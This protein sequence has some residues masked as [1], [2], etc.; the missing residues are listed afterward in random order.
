MAGFRLSLKGAVTATDGA[1]QIEWVRQWWDLG[2]LVWLVATASVALWL[3]VV[4][5]VALWVRPRRVR[6]GPDE[7]DLPGDEPP[8][9]ASLIT[10]SWS[11]DRDAGPATLLDLVARGHLSLRQAGVDPGAMTPD[12]A[13]GA[14]HVP[15]EVPPAGPGERLER[16]ERQVLDHVRRLAERT[17]ERTVPLGALT[18]GT[19]AQAQKW[20]RRFRNA[21]RQDARDRGLAGKRW[22]GRHKLL[23][24]VMSLVPALTLGFALATVVYDV[25][26][27]DA[28]AAE[29]QAPETGTSSG[30]ESD[31][32]LVYA[33]LVYGALFLVGF[34]VVSFTRS[35]LTDTD[36]GRDQAARW[37]GW[38]STVARD[39]RFDD[40]PAARVELWGRK[41]AYGAALGLAPDAVR[42]LPLGA[43]SR[44]KLWSPV[45]GRWRQV[46]VRRPL[47]GGVHPVGALF[48][49]GILAA[50]IL[51]LWPLLRDDVVDGGDL[52]MEML[53]VLGM[54]LG[55][56]A[57]GAVGFVTGLLAIVLPRR[58]V[59]GE[60][61]AVRKKG[62][63]RSDR[64]QVVTDDGRSHRLRAWWVDSGPR[65]GVGD[66]VRTRVSWGLRHAGEVQVES[67]GG[68]AASEGTGPDRP[69]AGDGVSSDAPDV[70]EVAQASGRSVGVG[71]GLSGVS[72]AV[73]RVRPVVVQVQNLTD[74]TGGVDRPAGGL[75]RLPGAAAVSEILERAV[76]LHSNT[77]LHPP[78]GDGA[79]AAYELGNGLI[80]A[81]WANRAAYEKMERPRFGR[82]DVEGVGEAA[83]RLK[84]GG[85]LFARQGDVV[86]VVVSHLPGET[87]DERNRLTEVLAVAVL[88]GA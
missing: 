62:V 16:Y 28:A 29:D 58:S 24:F 71:D 5:L 63:S 17:D 56:G 36:P 64:W 61:L 1:N 55:L 51:A 15:D 8:A 11:L 84:V 45:G 66:E 78:E 26:D 69:M 27:E 82:R 72:A 70:A 9:V 83:Y 12:R 75:P 88:G 3:V 23:L 33:G 7:L 22:F 47:F 80:C 76:E 54:P 68:E 39:P 41:L 18:T 42:E 31:G 10:R 53:P 20:W 60:V 30:E 87:K 4:W 38:R 37:L 74:R 25:S 67:R 43:A 79:L 57:L 19:R 32:Y 40:Q 52:D 48:T 77:S 49:G 44:R 59:A 46:R 73:T 13:R 2:A 86:L 85:A 34:A 21:V 35:G 81:T 65:F 50:P 14:I 6:P